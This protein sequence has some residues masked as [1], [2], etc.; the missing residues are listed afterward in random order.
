MISTLIS[1]DRLSINMYL[2]F[3]QKHQ[4]GKICFLN[5]IIPREETEAK[6]DAVMSNMNSPQGIM[7]TYYI[8]K[9]KDMVPLNCLP[10]KLK[11]ISELIVWIDLYSTEWVILKDKN[12]QGPALLAE[13]NKRV[14]IMNQA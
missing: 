5:A 11:N 13:W 6:I 2:A 7:F 9:A 10:D 14:N 1:P 4:A 8:K 3:M 12:N